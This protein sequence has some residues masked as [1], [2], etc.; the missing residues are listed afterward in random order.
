M[1]GDFG[2]SVEFGLKLAKRVRASK[3]QTSTA[4]KPA[5]GMDRFPSRKTAYDPTAPMVYA[6][7]SDPAI[8]DNPEIPSYQPYVYGRC[9]PPALI[10]LEMEEIAMEVDCCLDSAFVSVRGSWRVHCVSANRS[11]NCR[12][13]VPMGEQGSILSLE[14]DVS[15][16]SY[17]TQIVQMEEIVD[18]GNK[19]KDENGCFLRP[20]IFSLMI[21]RV[22]GGSTLSIN[23]SWFQQLLYIDG[24]FSLNVP[25]TFPEYVMPSVKRFPTREKIQLNVN[26][27]VGMEVICNTI[28]HPLKEMRRQMGKLGFSYEEDVITWSCV[29]FCFSYTVFSKEVVFLVD[30]SGSMRGRPLE[31]VKTALAACLSNLTPSDSFSIVAFNEESYLFSSSLELATVETIENAIQ[32]M[33]ECCVAGGGTQI[34][35]P[36]NKAMEMLSNCH[37]SVPHIFLITDGAVEDE[38]NIC[39]TMKT[40]ITSR[41]SMSPCISTFGIGSYCNHYFL[42]TLAH[43]GGGH[44][45][46]AFDADSINTG[47]QRLFTT[48]SSSVLRNISINSLFHLD[49]FEVYPF[50]IPDLSLECPLILSGRYLGKFPEPLKLNGMLADKTNAVIDMKVQKSKDIPLDKVF[51]KRQIDV[52][53]SQA[54]F[55]ES[56]QLEE[57]VMKLSVQTGFISEYTRMVLSLTDKQKYTMESA[58]THK[59]KWTSTWKNEGSTENRR[60]LLNAST[61]IGF[62]NVTATMENAPPLLGEEK[63]KSGGVEVLNKVTNC[64]MK[65]GYCC[66]PPCLI[67]MCSWVSGECAIVTTQLCAALSCLG[68]ISFCMEVCECCDC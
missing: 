66:C 55:L 34:L 18:M 2:Q 29:D 59:A 21:P 41:G 13:V 30:I 16:R 25:F 53:T 58:G 3:D 28:S 68:C 9:D 50:P 22:Y 19:A 60:I 61:A 63:D 64:C 40:N 10:P 15:G 44:Y 62:G 56:K 67:N 48:A 54:W 51:A 17:S 45:D 38:R 7:I 24:H 23:I 4:P 33:G 36:L 8:V 49:S 11:C 42:R 47:M 32:W 31:N 43:I 65:M 1:A 39:Q 26:T 52:L 27:G 6:V 5:A 57:K 12:I 20:Q 14:V 37:D 35:P 46:A